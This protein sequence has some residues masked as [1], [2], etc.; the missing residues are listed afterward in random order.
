MRDMALKLSRYFY[1]LMERPLGRYF[2]VRSPYYQAAKNFEQRTL[3]YN[4]QKTTLGDRLTWFYS[5]GKVIQFKNHFVT[6]NSLLKLR[7]S[8][9]SN[10]AD[11]FLWY[12]LRK[13]FLWAM[14]ATWM[15]LDLIFMIWNIY[16]SSNL[17]PLAK[18]NSSRR[19]T[20]FNHGTIIPTGITCK[21]IPC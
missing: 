18:F 20:K 5:I 3:Y 4:M 19:N 21:K 13:W 12:I 2:Q 9:F 10:T 17:D 8:L 11:L 6:I 1:L 15:R 16:I 14:V 7:M